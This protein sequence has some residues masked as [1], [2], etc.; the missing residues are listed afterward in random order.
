MRFETPFSSLGL[1]S[2][3][4][5]NSICS[6]E[7]WP[8][9]FELRTSSKTLGGEMEVGGLCLFSRC[10]VSLVFQPTP[11]SLPSKT[12]RCVSSQ[13]FTLTRLTGC[14][15]GSD[16]SLISVKCC[17]GFGRTETPG[18]G[19]TVTGTGWVFLSSPVLLCCSAVLCHGH[20]GLHHVCRSSHTI[21]AL[22]RAQAAVRAQH[23]HPT[24]FRMSRLR[25]D[26]TMEW[27]E[28]RKG[29]GRNDDVD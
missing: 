5:F 14:I 10:I 11:P 9:I 2:N 7:I 28:R 15:D 29:R 3:H 27:G 17:H 12:R 16:K 8:K 25:R 24:T 23:F 21:P 19:C 22:L 20:V 6:K 26:C 1:C 18:C 13:N 4:H